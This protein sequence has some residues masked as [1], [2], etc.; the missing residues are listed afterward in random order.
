M[1]KNINK[2]F[3]LAETLIVTTFVSGV[4][5]F[6][7][8]QF[9]TLSNKYEESYK[10]NTV[11]GLYSAR[12]IRNYIQ[13]EIH[14]NTLFEENINSNTYLNITNCEYFINS[15]YCLKLFELEN[16][17]NIYVTLN[18]FDK[19][20]FNTFSND[21]KQFINKINSQGTEKYR[22]LIE[23]NDSTFATIRF[24]E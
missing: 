23:Y 11:E 14:T 7:F 5:I 6:L 9:T 8:I 16:I 21:F 10:Y 2:G 4:L 13:T 15:D 24:G 18:A 20:L 19:D 12:N 3:A 17:N 1:K 22:L